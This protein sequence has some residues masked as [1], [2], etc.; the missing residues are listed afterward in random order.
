MNEESGLTQWEVD[1]G[2]INYGI[3]KD[4]FPVT[5][6]AA[7]SM[8]CMNS[9]VWSAK[10]YHPY[11]ELVWNEGANRFDLDTITDRE[12][13]TSGQGNTWT[14]EEMDEVYD[15]AAPWVEVV[16]ATS[17]ND[18][19]AS[20]FVEQA[21]LMLDK[22]EAGDLDGAANL[23]DSVRARI[24]ATRSEG[25]LDKSE[26]IPIN[27]KVGTTNHGDVE[28]SR[29]DLLSYDY[30]G[31]MSAKHRTAIGD[32][33]PRWIEFQN[34]EKLGNT[35]KQL[36]LIPRYTK[37]KSKKAPR[38]GGRRKTTTP[39][40]ITRKTR[41]VASRNVARPTTPEESDEESEP[42]P[43]PKVKK[44]VKAPPKKKK[45]VKFVESEEEYQPKKKPRK[46]PKIV[47]DDEYD[48]EDEDDGTYD[49]LMSLVGNESKPKKTKPRSSK[50]TML[51]ARQSRK[52]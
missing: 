44:T 20:Q 3:P 9:L 40:T 22:A 33:I 27:V 2:L 35:Y 8:L 36:V 26:M 51:K 10:K 42:E 32:F 23:A 25:W 39:V 46:K 4:F 41:R 43:T 1:M 13:G 45:V 11:Q 21:E 17:K 19:A 37:S 49:E 15:E 28:V 18:A 14:K 31:N 52:R 24:A 12:T 7:A 47:I 38:A 6:L 50:P 16:A 29:E 48:S 34:L 30:L 5:T